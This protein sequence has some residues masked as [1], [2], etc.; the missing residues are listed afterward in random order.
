MV[1]I[2]KILIIYHSG[3]GNTK[4]VA[5][6][7]EANLNQHTKVD[8]FSIEKIPENIDYSLYSGL[9]IGFPTIHTHPT[10]R[11]L[12]FIEQLELHCNALPVYIYTTYGLYTANTVR[13]FGKACMKKHML[14]V[15]CAS[16][17]CPA[18]DGVLLMPNIHYFR[19]M[20]K[21]ITRKINHDCDI[22]LSKVTTQDLTIKLPRFKLYSILNF[23]NKLAGHKIT[24]PIYLHKERCI[25]CDNCIKNCPTFALNRDS[26]QFPVFDKENCEKCYRCI[27]HCPQRALSLSKKKTTTFTL[28][29]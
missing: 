20:D 24:F 27:H 1:I 16:Y 9:V 18:T 7:I 5:K 15:C 25:K 2:M 12:Q 13:I 29:Y 21:N 28:N 8:C 23:P 19:K 4:K 6:L 22:F 11:I 10:K 14:P 26:K 3:V 17:R